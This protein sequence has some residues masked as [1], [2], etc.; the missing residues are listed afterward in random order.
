MAK[1]MRPCGGFW[2]VGCSLWVA[3]G[4]FTE[5]WVA[6]LTVGVEW[7]QNTWLAAP[8]PVWLQLYTILNICPALPH[9]TLPHDTTHPV[10]LP[11]VPGAKGWV[12]HTAP[13]CSSPSSR[14]FHTW[15]LDSFKP[16]NTISLSGLVV[17]CWC[18]RNQLVWSWLPKKA[19]R[20]ISQTAA[21][22]HY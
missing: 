4:C 7:T 15:K 14:L 20:L 12:G 22:W 1:E 17:K 9:H 21:I 3:V 5:L 11:G 6:S 19:T 2:N 16:H 18:R 10:W 8:P 13:F